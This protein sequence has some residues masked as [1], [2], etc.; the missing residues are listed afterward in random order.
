MGSTEYGAK[1]IVRGEQVRIWRE[2]VVALLKALSSIFLA[3]VRASQEN[4]SQTKQSNSKWLPYEYYPEL[5]CPVVLGEVL[6][7]SFR[8]PDSDT[9]LT[10]IVVW[11]N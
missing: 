3:R 6:V 2:V 8:F 7:I 1:I 11:P 4:L 9:D 5:T 10:E